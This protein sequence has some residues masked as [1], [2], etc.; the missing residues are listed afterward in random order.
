M[1]RW[2]PAVG[3]HPN[4]EADSMMTT[5]VAEQTA[6]VELSGV[7]TTRVVIAD[8]HPLVLRGLDAL[9]ED[10]PEFIVVD[11]CTTGEETIAAIQQHEPDVV[12]VDLNM[13]DMD[14]LEVVRRLRPLNPASRFVLLTAQIHEDQLIE[15]L[16]LGV[17][18]VVLKEMAPKLLVQ[19][20]RR[21]SAGGQWLEKESASRAMTK[22]VRREAKARELATLLTPREVEVARLVARGG[23]N[24]DI[25][26]ALFIA[27]GTV[28]IHL[29]NIYEKTNVSR[30]AEL[31][32]F[33]Q[34]YGL[35]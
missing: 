31:V 13:P 10:H 1:E 23:T 6:T 30:R 9:L 4:G 35:A 12:V 25:A 15:S 18:G 19:C 20:L 24:K 33:A 8:D 32:R 34:E 26:A 3:G 16:R 29:H 17:S 7:R 21:V 28:K 2:N 14:G 11:R 27:E 22:L 5:G